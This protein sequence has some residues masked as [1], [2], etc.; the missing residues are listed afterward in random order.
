MRRGLIPKPVFVGKNS[1]RLHRRVV[2]VERLAHSHQHDV[3]GALE[4]VE[5]AGENADLADDFSGCQVADDAHSSRQA[6]A[7]PHGASH[8]RR[9]AERVAPACRE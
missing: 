5:C 8:L 9:H 2:V 7:A 6:E 1:Q 3:E 4:Q